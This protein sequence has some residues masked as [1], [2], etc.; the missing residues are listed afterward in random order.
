[1]MTIEAREEKKKS[2]CRPRIVD[3]I[4]SSVPAIRT[5]KAALPWIDMSAYIDNILGEDIESLCAGRFDDLYRIYTSHCAEPWYIL[6]VSAYMD[7]SGGN[8]TFWSYL[9]SV[10][11][12]GR[13]KTADYVRPPVIPA[14][15]VATAQSIWLAVQVAYS[16]A[17]RRKRKRNTLMSRAVVRQ[18]LGLEDVVVVTGGQPPLPPPFTY[19]LPDELTAEV[20][21]YLH[22]RDMVTLLRVSKPF[23][24]VV[25]TELANPEIRRRAADHKRWDYLLD[26]EDQHIDGLSLDDLGWFACVMPMDLGLR[27]A[28]RMSSGGIA[29]QMHH[30]IGTVSRYLAVRDAQLA[31]LGL[32]DVTS[33]AFGFKSSF[34]TAY[35]RH[36]PSDRRDAWSAPFPCR[37]GLSVPVPQ[38]NCMITSRECTLAIPAFVTALDLPSRLSDRLTPILTRARPCAAIGRTRKT[39]GVLA[40]VSQTHAAL[41]R[42]VYPNGV[43]EIGCLFEVSGPV[44]VR[45]RQCKPLVRAL[46]KVDVRQAAHY[47]EGLNCSLTPPADSHPVVS[48]AMRAEVLDHKDGRLT[49][50]AV[51]RLLKIVSAVTTGGCTMAMTREA[52]AD[53][54]AL[55]HRASRVYETHRV[56]RHNLIRRPTQYLGLIA[57]DRLRAALAGMLAI[58]PMHLFEDRL[59]AVRYDPTGVCRALYMCSDELIANVLNTG[60][61]SDPNDLVRLHDW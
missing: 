13:I 9:E 59:D 39:L 4:V 54:S 8:R 25:R 30:N 41:I 5:W 28:W 61:P 27:T 33:E 58:Q 11:I 14:E 34:A 49:S 2:A 26:E 7:G 37:I 1:M 53:T 10:L 19:T 31:R 44:G 56:L 15:P 12:A 60:L 42:T 52:Y 50:K 6:A 43:F 36:I 35:R 20:A 38:I 40:G 48:A 21:S 46:T 3:A 32:P 16:G 18:R 47:L 24:A 55:V 22:L 23:A 45:L 57:D 17:P 29:E 51:S